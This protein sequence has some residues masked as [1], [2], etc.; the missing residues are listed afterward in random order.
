MQQL[1]IDAGEFRSLIADYEQFAEGPP[2]SPEDYIRESYNLNLSSEY[3]GLPIKNPFG[4]GSGQLSLN[5]S[6]VKQDAQSGLGFVVL[7]TFIAQDRSGAQSMSD[8]AIP[9]ARMLT[10]RIKGTDGQMGW[11]V[12]W[13]GRGWYDTFDAYLAFFAESLE[14]ARQYEM[15]VAPSCK[16]HLPAYDE[17]EW[18]YAEYEYTTG[19]LIDVWQEHGPVSAMPIEKDFSPTLAGSDLA[20]Q[21]STVLGWLQTVGELIKRAAHPRQVRVGLK[22]FNA[23]FEDTFQLE[24]LRAVNE[25][26]VGDSIPDFIVYANRLFD[27]N[28]EFDGERGVA[29]GG[30]DLSTRNLSVLARLRSLEQSG[31]IPVCRIPISATGNIETGRMAV[32]YL[33]RG[34]SNFQLHTYFQLPSSEYRM[35]RPGKTACALHELY[36]HPERG[37]IAWLLHLRRALDWPTEWDIK[38]MA[39]YCVDPANRLWLDY[40]PALT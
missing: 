34:A 20:S 9:E 10:E 7:K 13:K 24:M 33:L 14:V 38:R 5:V 22:I 40:E 8:W 18:K 23:V 12:T 35:K 31:Q 25:Q 36:F 3:G 32:E 21:M 27:P 15:I 2:Q 11:T 30:P 29:Y 16:Y 6:Q 28:R 26:C 17:S 19:R 1:E 37:L 39:D 4:K